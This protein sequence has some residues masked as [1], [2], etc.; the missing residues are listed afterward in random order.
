MEK[1]LA[2]L[3]GCSYPPSALVAEKLKPDFNGSGALSLY[4]AT[5]FITLAAFTNI[6]CP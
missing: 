3:T 6:Q 2:I 4:K 5:T 1:V